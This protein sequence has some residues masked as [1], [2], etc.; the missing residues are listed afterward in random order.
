[1]ARGA[2]EYRLESARFIYYIYLSIVS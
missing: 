2:R 1:M